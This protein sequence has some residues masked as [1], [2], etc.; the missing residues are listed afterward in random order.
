LPIDYDSVPAVIWTRHYAYFGYFSRGLQIAS[1]H[2]G[3]DSDC[4]THLKHENSDFLW[5][6]SLRLYYPSQVNFTLKS[7]FPGNF[8]ANPGKNGS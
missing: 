3:T 7:L 5:T 6:P 1:H 4:G 8:L 2:L